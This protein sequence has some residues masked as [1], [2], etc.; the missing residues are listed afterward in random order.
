VSDIWYYATRNGRTGPI[1]TQQLQAALASLNTDDVFVWREGFADWKRVVDVP[2]LGARIS[3]PQWPPFVRDAADTAA[4]QPDG[5]ALPAKEL[6]RQSALHIWFSFG[7]RLNRAPF[8][9][10]GFANLLALAISIVVAIAANVGWILFG[11][12]L[13]ATIISGFAI[14]VKRLHDRDK[15]GWWVLLFYVAPSVASAI[16]TASGDSGLLAVAGLVN[17]AISIWA[18]VEM[19]CLRGTA[20]TNRYGPDPLS[21]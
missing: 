8:W 14:A 6:V 19:G 5:Q 10:V 20:G 7:G 4:S 18:F 2:E 16:G 3:A 13:V 11:I 17:L 15:S 21:G 9:W 12:V 1:G